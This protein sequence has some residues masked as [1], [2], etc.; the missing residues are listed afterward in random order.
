MHGRLRYLGLRSH[1]PISTRDRGLNA[2]R[3]EHKCEVANPRSLGYDSGARHAP[4]AIGACAF[5]S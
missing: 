3:S 4:T 1:Q 5:D 2:S